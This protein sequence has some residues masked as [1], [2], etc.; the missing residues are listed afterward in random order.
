M[1]ASIMCPRFQHCKPHTYFPY[2]DLTI[3]S[4]V[5]A[6]IA[7][8][9]TAGAIKRLNTLLSTCVEKRHSRLKEW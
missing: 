5:P 7:E 1:V 4:M 3:L 8:V 6:F 2:M 9:T